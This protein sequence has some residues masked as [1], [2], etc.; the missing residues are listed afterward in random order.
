MHNVFFV[1]DLA[2][3]GGSGIPIIW[4]YGSTMQYFGNILAILSSAIFWQY[5]RN[6]FAI[7]SQYFRNIV[8]MGNRVVTSPV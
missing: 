5:F 3:T 4:Q 1:G 7:F 8:M 2:P 6:T